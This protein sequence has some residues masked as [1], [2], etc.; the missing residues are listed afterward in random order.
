MDFVSTVLA[1][2]VLILI[3]IPLV[4]SAC[5]TI[6]FALF[7]LLLR[8]SVVYLELGYAIVANFFTLPTSSTSS[9]L[10]FAPSEPQ[11]PISGNSRRNSAYSL[12]QS[13]R[14]NDPISSWT[15]NFNGLQD[16]YSKRKKKK[17][18]AR[19]MVE[20]HHLASSSSSVEY[21]RLP[22]S[23][24]ERRDFEGVGGWRSYPSRSKPRSVN[25]GEKP[26]SS[27]SSSSAHS[28]LGEGEG[29]VD[30]MDADERAWMSL[31]DRLELPSQVITFGAGSATPSAMSSPRAG[32]MSSSYALVPASSS[33]YKSH[34]HANSHI[35]A[36]TQY[37]ARRHHHR[38]HTTSALS[39]SD[40]R[41]G[42]GLS[43]S[44]STRPDTVSSRS[45]SPSTV[46]QSFMQPCSPMQRSSMRPL[47]ARSASHIV[48]HGTGEVNGITGGGGY[49]ALSRPGG[50]PVS[51]YSTMASPTSSRGAS[52]GAG[53]RDSPSQLTRF[54]AHYPTS[55]RHRRRSLSGPHAWGDSIGKRLA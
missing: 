53:D 55:V 16:G 28:I 29:D 42:S 51:S 30:E 19:S 25:G 50:A 23:G 8:L 27:A 14:N 26:L 52:P 54:M 7:T 41:D 38:S 11:T 36:G 22:V 21:S 45:V 31:N 48:G 49:F 12:L 34:S 10:P 18:Y 15:S 40:L 32:S 44:L 5:L 20:A 46:R 13:R 33:F 6:S 43:L 24:D 37:P 3:S 39:T 2:P 9:F 17:S 35:H 1:L 47:P 4:I